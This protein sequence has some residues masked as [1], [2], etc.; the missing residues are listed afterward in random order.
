MGPSEEK[1]RRERSRGSLSKVERER[2][3][4]PLEKRSFHRIPQKRV[5]RAAS[6]GP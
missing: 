1:K 3:E 2:L 5:E 6:K 4:D